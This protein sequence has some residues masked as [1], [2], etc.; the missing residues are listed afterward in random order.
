[1][2]FAQIERI[3]KQALEPSQKFEQKP[4]KPLRLDKKRAEEQGFESDVSSDS[5]ESEEDPAPV[6]RNNLQLIAPPH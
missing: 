4:K 1:M 5:S 2:P 3:M 6:Q